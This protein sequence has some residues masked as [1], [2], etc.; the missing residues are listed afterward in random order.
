DLRRELSHG[1]YPQS[2]F[3]GAERRHNRRIDLCGTGDWI[4]ADDQIA[5]AAL[6]KALRR[7]CGTFG[8]RAPEEIPIEGVHR[9]LLVVRGRLAL[10]QA[11]DQPRCELREAAGDLVARPQLCAVPG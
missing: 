7:S 3:L 9:D 5:D 10:F 2:M 1:P 4:A 6:D 11:F 8:S